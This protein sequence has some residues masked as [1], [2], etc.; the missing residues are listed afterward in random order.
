MK[1]AT[2]EEEYLKDSELK[3]E[4]VA[5]LVKWTKTQP[6]L[7]LV[8]EFEAIQFLHSNYFDIEKAKNTIENYYTFRTKFTELF[9]DLNIES[10][11]MFNSHQNM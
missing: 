10:D 6:H 5:E 11:E 9:T 4:D 7:P 3:R 8:T 2:A 1:N